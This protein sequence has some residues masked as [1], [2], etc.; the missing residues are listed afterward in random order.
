MKICLVSDYL[1]VYHE[2]WSGA[3]LLCFRLSQMILD[4]GNNEVAF[5]TR[6]SKSGEKPENVFVAPALLSRS[7]KFFKLFPFDFLSIIPILKILIKIKPDIVHINAKILFFPTL[8][9]AKILRLP[10]VF[11]VPDYWIVCP[12]NILVKP[13]GEICTDF[14]GAHC[15]NCFPI[16]ALQQIE[17][18]VPDIFK[19]AVAFVRS[20]IFNYMTDQLDSIVVLSNTSKKR[21][22]AYGIPGKKISVIYHYSMDKRQVD[23]G[24]AR[25]RAPEILFVG[26]FHRHKGMHVVVEAF[27]HVLKE[28]PDAFLTVIGSG[29]ANYKKEIEKSVEALKLK[30]NI[31]FSGQQNNEEVARLISKSEVVIVAEQWPNDFGPM[32][33]VEAKALGKPVVAGRIGAIPEFIS[34]GKD[35]LLG[36]YDDPKEYANNIIWMLRH[37]EEREKMGNNAK[38]SVQFLYGNDECK[39]IIQ[40]YSELRR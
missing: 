16:G 5:I 1:P 27:H 10:T 24:Y 25:D 20:K 29:D 14:Q 11:T 15:F 9:A 35:G 34:D 17:K 39:K 38:K 40:L 18:M 2:K 12:L 7:G 4:E 6:E 26:S 23:E 32:I 21:L 36:I 3:E 13:S 37:P 31:M 8:M 22:E 28:F 30:N 33:L 19:E